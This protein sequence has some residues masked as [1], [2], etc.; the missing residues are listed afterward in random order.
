MRH[1]EITEAPPESGK[2]VR[3]AFPVH[4][5]AAHEIPVVCGESD[6]SGGM[7]GLDQRQRENG[8]DKERGQHEQTLEKIR[9]AYCLKTAH[10]RIPDNYKR[11]YVHCEIGIDAKHGVKQ[12]AARLDA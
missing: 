7:S 9:P 6:G 2:N 10:E 8:R 12:S 5:S 4:L 1:S 11:G 3:P